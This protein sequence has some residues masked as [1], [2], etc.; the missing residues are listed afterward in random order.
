MIFQIAFV[1]SS[2][3]LQIKTDINPKSKT[4]KAA[5]IQ[6]LTIPAQWGELG[7]IAWILEFHLAIWQTRIQRDVIPPPERTV[8]GCAD[9]RRRGLVM[10]T[11]AQMPSMQG[12]EGQQMGAVVV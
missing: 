3:V 6:P 10:E 8:C 2:P 1:Q 4:S 11:A 5:E 7:R 9:G 12:Q